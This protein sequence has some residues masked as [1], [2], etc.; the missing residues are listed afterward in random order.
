MKNTTNYAL[1][2]YESTDVNDLTSGYNIAMGTLDSKLYEVANS[3]YSL[4]AATTSTLG[5]VKVGTNLSITSDGT[6]SSTNTTYSAA[7][8]SASGLMSAADKAKLDGIASGANKYSLPA[9]TTSTLGGV[10]VGTNLS[11]TS[12]GTLSST[13]TTYSAAT[14][15]ASGLMSA[16]DKAKLDGIASGANKYSLPA[17]TAST[18]GG[19]KVGTGLSVSSDGTTTVNVAELQC[20]A[21]GSIAIVT[22]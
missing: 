20:M 16:A 17:A 5:G 2:L 1:P 7:T 14:T 6:L 12:D 18:L 8:T 21:D 13:N 9:A 19:V 4:P 22:S 11:I 15:S 10:K 3:G